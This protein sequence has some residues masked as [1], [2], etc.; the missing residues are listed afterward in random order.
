MFFSGPFD[1]EDRFI[2][3]KVAAVSRRIQ[4]MIDEG[5]ASRES[6]FG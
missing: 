2:D 4:S 1:D 3:E 6:V 5:L